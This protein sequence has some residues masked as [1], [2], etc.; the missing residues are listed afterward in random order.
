L[1]TP[2]ATPAWRTSAEARTVAVS[3]AT[4]PDRPSAKTVTE[5]MTSVQ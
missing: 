2:L 3:G 5:G 4:T 1:L